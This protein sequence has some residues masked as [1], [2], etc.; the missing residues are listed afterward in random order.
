MGFGF[1]KSLL[2]IITFLKGKKN[3]KNPAKIDAER[4]GQ[5]STKTI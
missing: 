4:F 3:E 2:K 1:S 5:Q